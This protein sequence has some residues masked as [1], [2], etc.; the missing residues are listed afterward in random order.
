VTCA[1]LQIFFELSDQGGLDGEFGMYGREIRTENLKERDNFEDL[2]VD[3]R[4]IFNWVL[5]K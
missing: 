4:I 5:N 3:G 1:S 2:G